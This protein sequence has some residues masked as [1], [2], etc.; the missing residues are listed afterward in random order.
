MK[1]TIDRIDPIAKPRWQ[2]LA[3]ELQDQLD[4]QHS[5]YYGI[6]HGKVKPLRNIDSSAI[7][8]KKIEV[9]TT[10]FLAGFRNQLYCEPFDVFDPHMPPRGKKIFN[11]NFRPYR[12][13]INL[14]IKG[15]AVTKEKKRQTMK[16]NPAVD[17]K[18]QLMYQD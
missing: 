6:T 3:I 13:N 2:Q 14:E 1:N 17:E 18:T 16:I 12:S 10:S 8:H 5:V 4:A 7:P 9:P 11:E 15:D